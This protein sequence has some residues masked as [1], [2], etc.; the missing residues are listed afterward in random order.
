MDGNGAQITKLI[1]A[2]NFAAIKHSSQKRKD[3]QS[4]PY[5]NHPIG[6][7]QILVVEG[8][9]HDVDTLQAALLH[10]TVEDTDTSLD[11]IHTEFG[12]HVMSIVAEVTDDKNL[13]KAARK[14]MQVSHAPG[15]STE[16]KLVKLADKLYNLRDLL[17]ATPIGWSEQ[18]VTEYFQ[19]AGRVV[20]GLRGV[21]KQLEKRLD[22]VLK[23]GISQK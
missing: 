7:A 14:E 1:H 3:P 5:I 15:L 10:D 6:V 22:E 11:E 13:L 4:T 23:Q 21:N 19:W 20:D 17:R 9:V 8:G 16:A 2:T 12:S 18:R